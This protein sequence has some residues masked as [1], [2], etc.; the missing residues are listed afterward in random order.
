MTNSERGGCQFDFHK[1]VPV[2]NL[3][4]FG[5]SVLLKNL[6]LLVECKKFEIVKDL[7]RCEYIGVNQNFVHFLAMIKVN[8]KNLRRIA[9]FDF[10]IPYSLPLELNK[11]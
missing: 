7:I 11:T 5:K 3:Q 4:Y 1:N 10:Q 8:S 9:I 6:Q 2:L